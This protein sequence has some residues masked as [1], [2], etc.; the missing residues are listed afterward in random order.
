MPKLPTG[1]SR[2]WIPKK[3]THMREVDNTSFYNSKRWRS[4]RN[5]FI[6]KS[7]LCEH[8]KRDGVITGAQMVDHIKPITMGGSP[9]DQKNLQSLCTSCH[10]SKSGKESAEKRSTQREYKRK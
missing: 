2:P 3:P 10:N 5:Y 9:V 1:K 7:P 6:Q 4:L 8:C